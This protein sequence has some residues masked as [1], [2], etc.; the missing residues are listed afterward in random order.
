MATVKTKASRSAKKSPTKKNVTESYNKPKLYQGKQYTGMAVG[1]TI[2]WQYDPGIWKDIKVT[3]DQWDITFNVT[4]RRRGEAPEG[5]GAAVGTGYHW[6]IIGHQF[7]EKLNADDYTTRLVGMKFKLAHKRADK[8]KWSATGPTQHKQLIR[9][10]KNVIAGLEQNPEMMIPV[11]LNFEYRNKSYTGVGIPIMSSCH[12]N[13]CYELDIT[14]NDKHLGILKCGAKGWR[15]S[16]VA[17]GLVNTIGAIV[18]DWY[19]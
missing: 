16:G 17:Q 4:K 14:L 19:E 5:S 3:P 10:L 6:L 9:I 12:D 13:N 2:T 1:R 18:H 8:D 11:Q 15:I 7:V